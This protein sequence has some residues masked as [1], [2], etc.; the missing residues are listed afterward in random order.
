MSNDAEIFSIPFICQSMALH[1]GE[2]DRLDRVAQGLNPQAGAVEAPTGVGFCMALNRAFLEKV[3]VF[4]TAF[5]RGYGE[6]TD[7]CQKTRRLGGHHLGLAS[8]FVEHHGAGSF[9]TEEKRRRVIESAEVIAT[10]YP[11]YDQE[12]GEFVRL[13]PMTT[14]RLALAIALAA[15]RQDGLM[16]VYLAH[17]MGGGAEKYL[18]RRIAEDTAD[19]GHALVLRVGQTPRWRLELHGA[20]HVTQGLCADFDVVERLLAPVSQRNIVYNCA[21]GD[22]DMVAIPQIL[23]RLA[24]EAVSSQIDILMHDYL[25]LSPSYTLLDSDGVFRG[26]ADVDTGD[27]AHRAPRPDAPPASLVDWRA[28][29]G[30]VMARA[31]EITVFSEASRALVV[32]AYPFAASAIRCR[33]HLPLADIPHVGAPSGARRPVI[34]VLGNVGYQ[35]GAAVL[36]TLSRHLS[37]SGLADLVVI[38]NLD[39]GYQLASSARVHGSYR[40]ADIPALVARYGITDWL[41]PSVWPETFSFATREALATGLP[42]WC[43]DLG[44]QAEAVRDAAQAEGQGGIIPLG[45]DGTMD[46]ER[47]VTTVL[48]RW[49][50]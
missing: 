17:A 23:E 47:L 30:R 9:G 22:Q 42:V 36:A 44:A 40:H 25:P 10:R 19:G 20:G 39:P 2:A 34:G 6:E 12:V 35:K 37:K 18:L 49:H 16:P 5:G 31:N 27:S 43:F 48:E 8:L 45:E 50:G 4:D 14:A 7:W 28:A 46:M 41:I 3:P 24:D 21:V 29:W 26:L 13:D 1:P 15:D 38:G 11:T 32:Q 33:P